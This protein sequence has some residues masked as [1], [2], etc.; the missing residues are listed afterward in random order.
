VLVSRTR[1][2]SVVDDVTV[3]L[4]A[5]VVLAVVLLVVLTQ[6]WWLF[7]VLAL[8]FLL[9][10]TLGPAAS[11]VA[12]LVTRVVRPR[13]RAVPHPTPGAPKRFAAAMGAAMT[14]AA[15]LLWVLHATTGSGA[16]LVAVWV[17]AGV[18]VV[19]PALEAVLGLC[20]GCV[21]FSW[22]MRAGIVPESVCVECADITARVRTAAP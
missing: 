9:R 11:P 14:A 20:V 17:I 16:A 18:M 4:V 10:S 13:V 12:Q 2:P 22:L 1:F 19:F 6:Q 7:A 21:V 3:R 15:T 5:G 8:D